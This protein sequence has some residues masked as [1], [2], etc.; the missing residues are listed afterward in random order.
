[1]KCK[2]CL[3]E[4]IADAISEPFLHEHQCCESCGE[5]IM[6]LGGIDSETLQRILVE[7]APGLPSPFNRPE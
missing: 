2:Y 7:H 1:M 5:L 6:A 4:D 3:T